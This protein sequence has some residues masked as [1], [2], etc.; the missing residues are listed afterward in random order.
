MFSANHRAAGAFN[1]GYE[2]R[3]LNRSIER[4]KAVRDYITAAKILAASRG[5]LD[6]ARLLANQV[7]TTRVVDIVEHGLISTKAAVPPLALSDALA[8]YRPMAEGFFSRLAPFSALT[9]IWN[10]GGWFKVALRTLVPVIT[11]AP[12]GDAVAEATSKG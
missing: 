8:W 2:I 6:E 3:D 9:R 12:A 7:G 4:E 11:S 5:R 10:A 1:V